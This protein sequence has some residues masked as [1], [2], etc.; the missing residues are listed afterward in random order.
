M[1]Y[2]CAADYKIDISVLNNASRKPYSKQNK[3]A[4][5]SQYKT[6]RERGQDKAR[7]RRVKSHVL[8]IKKKCLVP[9]STMQLSSNFFQSNFKRNRNLIRVLL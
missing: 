3:M 5:A 1:R 8:L 9:V 6:N 2:I 4:V 7:Q